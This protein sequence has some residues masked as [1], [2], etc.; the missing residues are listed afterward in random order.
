MCAVDIKFSL[1]ILCK[2]W[3]PLP[4]DFME[5]LGISGII[6]KKSYDCSKLLNK[7][8]KE[9]FKLGNSSSG[10]WTDEK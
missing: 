5:I 3:Q 10:C 9:G 6:M 1:N 4:G 7:N 2:I 8:F